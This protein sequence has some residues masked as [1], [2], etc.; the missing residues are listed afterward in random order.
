MKLT[1]FGIAKAMGSSTLTASGT[2]VGTAQ[3]LSPEQATG[4][5]VSAS[6]DV[7]ALGIVAFEMLAGRP[8]F[9]GDGPVAVALAQVR[10][11]PPPLPVTVPPPLTAL[12]RDS[13][14]KDPARR[15]ADGAEFAARLRAGVQDGAGLRTTLDPRPVRS[16]HTSRHRRPDHRA[17]QPAPCGAVRDRALRRPPP[18]RWSRARPRASWATTPVRRPPSVP[19]ATPAPTT[20]AAVTV[21]P[22]TTITTAAPTTTTTAAPTTTL[23]IVE[24]VEI[25][26]DDIVGRRAD[27]VVEELEDVGLVV[28][29]KPVESE[30]RDATG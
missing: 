27:D 26:A 25:V 5:A 17:P 8:P 18:V 19:V 1:D 28:I 15:P 13:L 14:A 10:D 3:Y 12:V 30:P 2:V 4:G 22:A 6:S 24:I 16:P 7:Y 29:V 21:V 9:V 20:T 11:A 23:P